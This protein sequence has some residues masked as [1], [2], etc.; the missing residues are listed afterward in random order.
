[1][2]LGNSTSTH[3]KPQTITKCEWEYCLMVLESLQEDTTAAPNRERLERLIARIYKRVRKH[4]RQRGEEAADAEDR[5]QRARANIPSDR[6]TSFTHKDFLEKSGD[7]IQAAE[8]NNRVQTRGVVCYTCRQRFNERHFHYTQLC[9]DCAE[10]QFQKRHQR[11][12]LSGRRA[13]VTGGRIKIGF[14]TAL[15]L[16]RDGAEV[17][18]TTRF[19]RDAARR[20]AEQ[21]DFADWEQRLQIYRLDFRD[22]KSVLAFTRHLVLTLDSL[23]ILVNNAAQTI[24]RPPQHY[25]QLAALENAGWQSFP[26]NLRPLIGVFPSGQSHG[27]TEPAALLRGEAT[28]EKASL[29]TEPLDEFGEPLD[30]R[31][32]NSWIL[33]LDEVSPLELLE[34]LVIN[35]ATPY[36]LTSELKPLFLRSPRPDR[37]V[38]NVV[39]VDGLFDAKRKSATH[40]HLNMSKAALNMMTRTSAEDFASDGIFMNSVDTGWITHEGPHPRRVRLQD[41]GVAP[42][43]D[44]I[45]GAARIYDPIVRGTNGERLH[46]MIFRN[47]EPASW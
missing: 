26:S 40:P 37:Y 36:L 2:Q 6:E 7:L 30:L 46:G 8:P 31:E 4:R 39:G 1:M 24:Q 28:K 43:L 5:Q 17:L 11:T 47:Y 42:P 25:Q 18:V 21:K 34:V 20:F 23:D 16:L 45:D 12:D 35:T 10:F 44:V 3:G 13:L 33:R 15:K 32:R 22:V 9:P 14:E 41:M 38:V 29:L 19:A 27:H